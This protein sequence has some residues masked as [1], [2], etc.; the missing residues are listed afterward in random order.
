MITVEGSA[1]SSAA[2]RVSERREETTRSAATADGIRIHDA[3]MGERERGLTNRILA[4]EKNLRRKKTSFFFTLYIYIVG[5]VDL[6]F[7]KKMFGEPLTYTH[8]S[9]RSLNFSRNF[10]FL[11][12]FDI[13]IFLFTDLKIL[14]FTFFAA[15][16]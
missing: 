10:F 9:N 5:A 12:L 3:A 11:I 2:A 16:W 6:A 14:K 15:F 8:F 7:L 1:S 4:K 13:K